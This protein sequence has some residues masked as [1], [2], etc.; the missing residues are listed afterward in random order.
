MKKYNSF[1]KVLLLAF[2]ALFFTGC[3][4]DDKYDAPNLD[5]FQCQDLV[6]TLSIAQVKALH[7]NVTY[8]F[9]D[10]STA[11]MEGYVSSTDETGNIYKT[12]YI[13]DSRVNPTQGFTISVDAVSTY[14]KYPQGS[15]IYIKL[16]GLALGTYGGLVQLGIKDSRSIATGVDAVS[17][18]P[19][20]L[21]PTK[22]FRS[23]A[24][25]ENIVPKVLKIS[26]FNANNNLLG[27]LIQ[28]S[29]VEFSKTSLCGNFAPDGFTVDRL[30]KDGILLQTTIPLQQ[31]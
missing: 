5:G 14:T 21:L 7:T 18:I 27:A 30:V 11:V 20:K 17:R 31:R 16:A 3:V 13:Q 10:N 28:V 12:I 9:P 15:K 8:V 4:H 2:T 26:D 19:E 1:L 25:I 29:E 22:M 24:P 23:C 6:A